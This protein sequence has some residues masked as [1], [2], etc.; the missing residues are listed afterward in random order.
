MIWAVQLANKRGKNDLPPNAGENFVNLAK[1]HP[2]STTGVKNFFFFYFTFYF[3]KGFPGGTV[4]KNLPVNT[5]VA[6][7]M[8]SIPGWGRYPV[9]GNGN[10]AVFLP[11]KSHRQ[12]SLVGY[13]PQGCKESDTTE[14]LRI[15][16]HYSKR[17]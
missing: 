3:I 8:G 15:H 6:R 10:P 4:V 17:C 5:R 12:R 14:Q 1:L 7:V 11:G 13:S 2:N 16:T 9:R